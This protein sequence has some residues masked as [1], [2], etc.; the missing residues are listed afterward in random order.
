M[1]IGIIGSP[2]SNYRLFFSRLKQLEEESTLERGARF[3]N[4]RKLY[5]SCGT[6]RRMKT[7]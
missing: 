7:P 3:L 5:M 6:P 1:E 2:N 4:W